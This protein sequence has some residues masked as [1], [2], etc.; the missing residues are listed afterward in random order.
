MNN[1]L[2]SKTWVKARRAAFCYSVLAGLAVAIVVALVWYFLDARERVHIDKVTT[3]VGRGI[4]ALIVKDIDNRT[5][6]LSRLARQWELSAGISRIDWETIANSIYEAQ[7]GYKRIGWVDTSLHVRWVVPL[8][9]NESALDFDLR[10][11]PPAFAAVKAAR[12]RNTVVF[13]QPLDSAHG[14]KGF[15]IYI[16]V[17]R[18]S[19]DGLKFDG[20]MG[21][22]LLIAPLLE[23]LFPLDLI[24]EHDLEISINGQSLFST[25]TERHE[26]DPKWIQ[27]RQFELYNLTWQLSV[28]P[29]E[30]S[31]LKAYTRFS[32][33]IITLL[34]LLSS[35]AALS[36]YATLISRGQAYQI[37]NNRK[38]MA[39]LFKNLPGMA[40][41]GFHKKNW[42][43]EFVSEGCK[44][45]TGYS[46]NDFEQQHILWGELIHPDDYACVYITVQ[47]AVKAN[48]AFE[49][50]YRILTKDNRKRWV[51][52]RGEVFYSEQDH[53]HR[54]EGFITDITDSKQFERGLIESRAFSDA[55]VEAAVEAV[56]TINDRGIIQA[57]NRAAQDM[58]GYILDETIGSHITILMPDSYSKKD[59][60]FISHS[61][62]TGELGDV[63]NGCQANAKRKDGFIFPIHISVSEI[64][65]H[66]G[67]NFVALIRDLSEQQA[68]ENA[69]RQHIE[70]LAHADR[71]NILGEMAVG[72]A[73]EINQPLTAISLYAQAGKRLFEKGNHTSIPDTFDK[74]SEHALRAGAVIERMQMMSKRGDRV[75]EVTDSKLLIEEIIKLAETEARIR[76]IT[77]RMEVDINLPLVL[78]DRVQIQQ[79]VLNL[80]R[81]GMDAMTS[82][83]C[84]HGNTI[85]LRARFNDSVEVCVIDSG[86][87]VSKPIEDK[88]FTPFLSTKEHGMGMGLSISQAII[89]EH[90]GQ[91]QFYN[92]HSTGATFF[93]TL[94]VEK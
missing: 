18:A 48:T 8:K 74:L 43:M 4:E 46:K 70:Q 63:G 3:S 1:H 65:S 31:V 85:L 20:F 54:I 5:V 29:K 21:S 80:L 42:P 58:F 28:I 35:I 2:E 15:G 12:D 64:D 22:V 88:L 93:F 16:P 89:A 72:I 14:G 86:D 9:E 19:L 45:L 92:N 91:L 41:R 10:S 57:F 59:E 27:Q 38:I 25:N 51:W 55:V 13:T 75:M 17:Y 6:S 37:R 82:V 49:M 26:V 84:R 61:L 66:I 76:D 30:A 83:G 40:Y 52:E 23:S 36:V 24:A 87:G 33:A 11:N 71:L 67:R 34:I 69:A 53:V 73:H 79:V 39:H 32:S 50:E 94:P 62:K 78:V 7:P 47:K 68:A 60:H 56:I 77:I 44:L 81:N 90:G